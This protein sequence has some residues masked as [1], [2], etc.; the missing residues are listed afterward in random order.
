DFSRTGEVE[1]EWVDLHAGLDST[2]N[3]VWNEIKYKAEVDKCYGQLPLVECRPSQINQVFMNLL[4]NAAQAIPERGRITISTGAQDG[5]V[6]VSIRDTGAGIPAAIRDRIF[7]PFFTTKPVGKGTGLGLSVSYGIIE[8]HG[9]RIDLDTT[10]GE[11]TTFTVRL[12]VSQA[13]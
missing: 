12:P 10:P 6:W 7:D 11:G 8:K 9:G 5:Q 1:M 4:V 13:H 3:V 2:L